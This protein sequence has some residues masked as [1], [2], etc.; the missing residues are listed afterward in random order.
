MSFLQ[1]GAQ[2]FVAH[3]HLAVM[4]G[5]SNTNLRAR[6]HRKQTQ[7]ALVKGECLRDAPSSVLDLLLQAGAHADLFLS[8]GL[9]FHLQLSEADATAPFH[10]QIQMSRS[11]CRS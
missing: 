10:R 6:P 1:Y 4:A 8:C 11:S 5:G 2:D 3:L 9:C 7:G